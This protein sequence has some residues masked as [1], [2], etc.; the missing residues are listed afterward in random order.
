MVLW[1]CSYPPSSKPQDQS[2]PFPTYMLAAKSANRITGPNA[3]TSLSPVPY[4]PKGT[5]SLP[6]KKSMK[7][8]TG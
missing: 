4:I 8:F 7:P 3:E 5:F 6:P 1:D 2:I